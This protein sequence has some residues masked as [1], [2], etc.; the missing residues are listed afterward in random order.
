MEIFALQTTE[1]LV[2]KL[3]KVYGFLHWL[4]SYSVQILL[5]LIIVQWCKQWMVEKPELNLMSEDKTLL[6]IP[7]LN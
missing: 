2:K 6:R 1:N 3:H 4:L 7:S 5:G